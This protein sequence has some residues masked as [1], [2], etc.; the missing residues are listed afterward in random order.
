MHTSGSKPARRS[1]DLHT[2]IDDSTVMARAMRS[3]FRTPGAQQ[4]SAQDNRVESVEKRR[5][6]AL[7]NCNGLLSVYRLRID[8]T[9]RQLK[10]RPD[11]IAS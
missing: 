5:Y 10:R 7:R 3:H 9:L 8:G 2:T 6:I 11:A 1:G 4:P